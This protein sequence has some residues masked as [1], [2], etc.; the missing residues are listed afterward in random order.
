MLAK[1][2]AEKAKADAIDRK[3]KEE[4]WKKEVEVP[5]WKKQLMD[6]KAEDPNR[7]VVPRIFYTNVRKKILRRDKQNRFYKKIV[8]KKQ[9][10]ILYYKKLKFL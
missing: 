6:K 1:K 10:N 2:A 7:W 8:L 4:G 5:D 9:F 3:K